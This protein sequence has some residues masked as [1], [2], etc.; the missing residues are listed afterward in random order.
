M[1]SIS[2]CSRTA[3]AALLIISAGRVGIAVE[4]MA[5]PAFTLIDRAGAAVASG[6]LVRPGPWGIVYVARRCLPC[7]SVLHSIDRPEHAAQAG[8]LVIVVANASAE[9][10]LAEAARYPNLATATWLADA[11]GAMH[12][13]LAGSGAPIV[14]GLRAQVIEWSLAGVFMDATDTSSMLLAWLSS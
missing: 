14:F 12:Q 6:R 4:R 8:R 13:Q 1:W 11:S 10:L 5:L 9:E 2:S 7:A 3:L